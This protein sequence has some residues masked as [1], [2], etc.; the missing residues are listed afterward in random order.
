MQSTD[1]PTKIDIAWAS[2]AGG[3]FVRPIP[4]TSQI[5]INDGAASWPDGWVPLNATP[6]GAGGIPPDI[7]DANGMGLAISGWIRWLTATGSPVPWDSAFSASIGGYPKGGVVASVTTFGRYWLS[8]AENNTTNPDTGGANWVIWSPGGGEYAVDTGAAN[9]LVIAPATAPAAYVDGLEFL[10]DPAHANTGATTINVS[11]LGVVAIVHVDGT[12]LLAGEVQAGQLVK[13]AYL[14]THFQ[15]LNAPYAVTQ[16]PLDDSTKPASTAYVDAAAAAIDNYSGNLVGLTT[17][18]TPG[19]TT[20]QISVGVG[21]CRDS[22]NAINMALG[23]AIAKD[24]T[25]TWAVG[26]GNGGRSSSWSSLS[27]G[28]TGYVYLIYNPTSHVTDAFL[29][30][31]PTAP[32]LPSG[33]T[34]FRRIGSFILE[35]ASTNIKQWVQIGDWFEYVTRSADYAVTS[36]GGGV[37]YYRAIS[38][39]V[40]IKV[41]GKF[42]FQSTGTANTTAFLSGVYDPDLGVPAAFGGPTQWAQIRRGA[43]LDP[44]ST[45]LSYGTVTFEQWTDASAHIYTFSSDNSDVIAL[46]VVAYQDLTLNRFF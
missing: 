27:A 5:G 19:H 4:D 35:A 1:I 24:L 44:T 10:V 45:P 18:N 32:T 36:N 13:L 43:Y 3:S 6:E 25:V 2:S 15:Y 37:S 22:T 16:A 40:G 8:T 34:Y 14:G 7:R 21:A 12:A 29:D 38:V 31:S 30:Q 23:S 33:Y 28:Q 11:G 17:S 9:A 20:T 42:Y 46:G 39:P 26:T 41:K